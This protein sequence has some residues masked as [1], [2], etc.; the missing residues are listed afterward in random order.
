MRKPFDSGRHDG[1]QTVNKAVHA[2]QFTGW[3]Y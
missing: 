1:I 2:V 3:W